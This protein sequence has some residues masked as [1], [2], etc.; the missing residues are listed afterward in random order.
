M[1]ISTVPSRRRRWPVE[2]TVTLD[3]CVRDGSADGMV[4]DLEHSSNKT[5]GRHHLQERVEKV[6]TFGAKI[7]PGAKNGLA[8]QDWVSDVKK[9]QSGWTS[10]WCL[11]SSG[12]N[13]YSFG[14]DRRGVPPMGDW[15]RSQPAGLGAVAEAA[16][17]PPER[18][19]GGWRHRNRACRSKHRQH[20]RC[21][22]FEAT[23]GLRCWLDPEQMG[24]VAVGPQ[25]QAGLEVFYRV[26]LHLSCQRACNE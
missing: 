17:L 4:S 7:G 18:P 26:P 10:S 21:T 14:R 23:S 2:L 13:H 22:S 11:S 25:L 24:G 3:A 5:Q 16:L 6:A 8:Y 19:A 15:R 9:P 20:Q 12:Q 1:S